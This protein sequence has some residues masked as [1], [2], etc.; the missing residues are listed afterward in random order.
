MSM[1]VAGAV[2]AVVFGTW[3]A[4]SWN[5]YLA[6]PI[7][8]AVAPQ[9]RLAGQLPLGNHSGG[10]DLILLSD[11]RALRLSGWLVFTAGASTLSGI[12]ASVLMQL[13]Q[14]LAV[15]NN[16]DNPCYFCVRMSR[17]A[18][19]EAVYRG[20]TRLNIPG[21]VLGGMGLFVAIAGVELLRGAASSNDINALDASVAKILVA[22]CIT[23]SLFCAARL[24]LHMCFIGSGS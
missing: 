8:A 11:R 13:L 14:M 19:Q 6:S 12:C 16:N 18:I 23:L 7:D 5:D 15:N 10:S 9:I 24:G 20:I 4:Q 21:T 1:Y 2:F 22:C 3:F 17:E